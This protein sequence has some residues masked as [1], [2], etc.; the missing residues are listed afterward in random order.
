M[1]FRI[2]GPIFSGDDFF[3]INRRVVDY[4]V[5]QWSSEYNAIDQINILRSWKS[6]PGNGSNASVECEISM[7]KWNFQLF[8]LFYSWNIQ[9]RCS[10]A[11]KL[12]S[13]QI[14][15]IEI[16]KISYI[17]SISLFI[18]LNCNFFLKFYWNSYQKSISTEFM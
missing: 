17:M 7:S 5:S 12:V 8:Y 2:N 18:P 9:G 13:L 14:Y 6:F 3:I 16:Q 10:D 4:Y 1:A 15:T 11:Q